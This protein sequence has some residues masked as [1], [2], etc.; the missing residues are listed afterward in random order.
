MRL[1]GRRRTPKVDRL[2]RKGKL[3]ALLEAARYSDRLVDRTGKVLDRGAPIRA[4]AVRAGAAHLPA[5]DYI[6]AYS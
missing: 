4:D 3:P 2:Q 5:R 6:D 1:L